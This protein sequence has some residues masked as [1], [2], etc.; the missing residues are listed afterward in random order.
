[1]HAL[2]PTVLIVQPIFTFFS[3]LLFWNAF[4]LMPVTSYLQ[5][6]E[7]VA[8]ETVEKED[9]LDA[10]GAMPEMVA[11]PFVSLLMLLLV[12]LYLKSAVV[13]V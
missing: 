3:F 13:K 12:T 1:M 5:L 10:V 9:L 8:M 2:E 4:A 7:F 11:V 6:S